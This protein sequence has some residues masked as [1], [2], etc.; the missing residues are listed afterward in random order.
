MALQVDLDVSFLVHF[1]DH[2]SYLTAFA[3]RITLFSSGIHSTQE[4]LH[5]CS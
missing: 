2:F 5:S 3:D 1:V 4:D